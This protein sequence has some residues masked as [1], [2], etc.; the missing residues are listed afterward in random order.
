MQILLLLLVAVFADVRL[1]NADLAATRNFDDSSINKNNV[2]K[3]HSEFDK[4]TC[5]PV[6]HTP[7]IYETANGNEVAVITDFGGCVTVFDLETGA[8]VWQRNLTADY[9]FPA[10]IFS[11]TAPLLHKPTQS[12]LLTTGNIKNAATPGVGVWTFAVSFS[13]GALRWKRL[14]TNFTWAMT[15][16]S[17][18][19]VGNTYFV[20]TSSNEWVPP[21]FPGYQCCNFAG[22]LFAISATNG[23]D[24]WATTARSIPA[25]LTGVGLYSGAA[26]WHT[27]AYAVDPSNGKPY[28]FITTGQLVRAPQDTID[29]L[30]LNPQNSSCV[31]PRVHYDAVLK[32]DAS[33]G[34]IVASASLWTPDIWNAACYYSTPA[35][36]SKAV[37]FDY[38]GTG[39]LV[40]KKTNTVL[41]TSKSGGVFSFD[42]NLNMRCSHLLVVGSAR[43][44]IR[45]DNALNDDDNLSELGFYVGSTNGQL[46]YFPLLNGTLV[47]TGPWIKYDGNCNV[48]W[49]SS[50]P[51]GFEA[52]GS[53]S[54]SNNLVITYAT[55]RATGQTWIYALNE[56]NGNVVWSDNLQEKSDVA[57][58]VYGKRLLT[59]RG[60]GN[61]LPNVVLPSRLTSYTVNTQNDD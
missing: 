22:E 12:L 3:L 13:D 27:P 45:Y 8:T 6:T 40:S 2:A 11:R 51:P 16:A 7:M 21:L 32:I 38:D 60:S 49:I 54:L 14:L 58:V 41:V 36:Q 48:K 33:N 30:A 19:L 31:D 5:G 43:G 26:M 1:P 35:C 59:G 55:E 56:Q 20:S 50:P 25:E 23:A 18:I 37:A 15:T 46:K 42:F 29:C 28:L 9:G 39:V 52:T 44:G 53:T 4:V 47:N 61:S 24:V 17:P 34:A 10:F 57:P